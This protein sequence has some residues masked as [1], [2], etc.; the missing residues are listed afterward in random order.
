MAGRH[1][2]PQPELAARLRDL[3]HL[4]HRVPIW[5]Q[6]LQAQCFSL[7]VVTDHPQDGPVR[8]QLGM[9]AISLTSCGD[10]LDTL[11]V[12]ETMDLVLRWIRRW[13]TFVVL[14]VCLV[15]LLNAPCDWRWGSLVIVLFSTTPSVV[16]HPM[17]GIRP[18]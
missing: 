2:A 15:F 12:V 4:K 13:L 14:S 3:V 16:R 7:Q 6:R 11:Q 10:W 18:W 8:E 1:Q 9:L 5:K 17:P